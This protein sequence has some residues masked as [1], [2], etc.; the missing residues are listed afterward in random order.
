MAFKK[1]FFLF[2]CYFIISFKELYI[3]NSCTKVSALLIFRD[4]NCALGRLNFRR[5]FNNTAFVQLIGSFFNNANFDAFT[6]PRCTFL[7]ITCD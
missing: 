5:S 7:K 4:S 1:V 3:S 2:Y 6:K